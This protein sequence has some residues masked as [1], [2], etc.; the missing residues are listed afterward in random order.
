M[1]LSV[2]MITYN[3]E[4]F[5]GQAIESV[6]AQRVNFDYAIVIGEDCSTDGTRAVITDFQRRY[7]DRI[8]S[9]LRERNVG[10]MRNFAETIG[11][12]RGQ[13]LAFLE[14]DDYWTSTDK[15]QKQVD[16]LDAH[17]DRSICCHRVRFLYETGSETFD[18]KFDV[19]PPRPAGPYTIEDILKGNFVMTCSTVLR[20]ELVSRFP[21]WFFRMKLG[22]WP[23][24]A[25]V[26]RH[27]KIELMDEV[28]AAYRVHPGCSWSSLP[29]S[30]RMRE[31]ARMLR[32]LDNE[33]GYRYTN[34]IRET[35]APPY[36]ELALMARRNGRRV[37]T[38]RHFATCIRN[39]GLR[40]PGTLRT[41]AGLATYM[42]IGSWYKVFSRRTIK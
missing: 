15:L 3:H 32:A 7:P 20:R 22:D 26:A 11:A 2:A 21:K 34:T 42:I 24:C 36:L 41:F 39:G 27:G 5:I 37:E 38:A 1:K 29:Q 40:L 9:L 12:C 33:L 13:Y 10:A 19:F 35:I 30:T 18:I 31:S 17:P 8:V 14:G 23:L 4:H 25:M 28:M 6:L 16:F